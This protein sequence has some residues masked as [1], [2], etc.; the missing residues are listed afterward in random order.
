M[1]PNIGLYC[2]NPAIV[3]SPIKCIAILMIIVIININKNIFITDK[4]F[5]LL[6]F[7]LQHLIPE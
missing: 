4:R 5:S 6:Q 3:S 1:G 2:K 7:S